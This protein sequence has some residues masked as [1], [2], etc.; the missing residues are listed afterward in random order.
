MGSGL[1]DVSESHTMHTQNPHTSKYQR[2]HLCVRHFL[3]SSDDFTYVNCRCQV[4]K[5]SKTLM[6]TE[7]SSFRRWLMWSKPMLSENQQWSGSGSYR[8]L[9]WLGLHKLFQKTVY[10]T[11]A[12]SF[13]IQKSSKKVRWS[14]SFLSSFPCLQIYHFSNL[15]NSVPR[16]TYFTSN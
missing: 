2:T 15:Y 5:M 11:S 3:V 6:S 14:I 4:R 9:G 12:I 8:K 13:V 16:T 1:F 10:S 7:L